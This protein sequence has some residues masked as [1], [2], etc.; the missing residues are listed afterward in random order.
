M[1]PRY[2]RA[3]FTLLILAIVFH[4]IDFYWYSLF[5]VEI[6]YTEAEIR[7]IELEWQRED[8][9]SRENYLKS[10]PETLMVNS[11]DSARLA[12]MKL[13]PRQIRSF[14]AYR[15][16]LGAYESA[17]QLYSIYGLDSSW[18]DLHRPYFNFQRNW[19]KPRPHLDKVVLKPDS[20]DPN[21]ITNE[22]MMAMG[23]TSKMAR[24]LQSFREKFRPFEQASDLYLIYNMDSAEAAVLEPFVV[25]AD[26]MFQFEKELGPI[27]LNTADTVAL[28]QIKGIGSFTAKE[29]V[30]Y[31]E[32]LGGFYSLDQLRELYFADSLWMKKMRP[33]FFLG[34]SGYNYI[35]INEANLEEMKEH[36]Y[37]SY[38]LARNIVEFRE[39]IGLFKKTEELANIELVDD[40][41]FRKL[42]PYLKV[43]ES[44]AN[45]QAINKNRKE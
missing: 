15:D 16:A 38:Y 43:S 17:D 9:I 37:I 39:R 22:A 8:S 29:I 4:V 13:N 12:K 45:G 25:L 10:L 6:K 41:L 7:S 5:P 11:L 23:F 35:N 27:D 40:V 36:P 32:K 31:R 14:L 30:A 1:S 19:D 21:L 28:R 34:S 3:T 18:V 20:F 2:R 33:Q 24:G 42:A 44:D 26:S